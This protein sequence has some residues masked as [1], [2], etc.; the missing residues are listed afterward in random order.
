MLLPNLFRLA[1]E[2]SASNDTGLYAHAS[3]GI[4]A[5]VYRSCLANIYFCYTSNESPA[6]GAICHQVGIWH[7]TCTKEQMAVKQYAPNSNEF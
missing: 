7:T 4:N 6:E 2:K 3:R 1:N 5:K